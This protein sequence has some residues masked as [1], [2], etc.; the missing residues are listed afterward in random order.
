[1]NTTDTKQAIID[2]CAAREIAYGVE[3]I[4]KKQPKEKSPQLHWRITLS[5]RSHTMSCE[6]KQGMG[7][8]VGYAQ[9]NRPNQEACRATCETGKLYK[10][11]DSCVWETHKDQPPPHL[12]NVLYALVSEAD[13]MNYLGFEDWASNLGYDPDSRQAEK[14]YLQCLSQTRDLLPVIGGPKGLAELQELFQNY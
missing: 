4:P 6:Y 12:A 7:H 11:T 8:V 5:R 13:V 2:W 10:V 14:I 9:Q 1:M 3:F